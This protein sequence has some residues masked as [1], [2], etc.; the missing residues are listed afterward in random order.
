MGALVSTDLG[1]IQL[2]DPRSISIIK[3]EGGGLLSMSRKIRIGA[4][5]VTLAAVTTM[6][7]ATT[8]ASAFTIKAPFE[9]WKVTGSL[10][11]KKLNQTIVFPEGGTF[12]G[13]AVVEL[14]AVTGSVTGTT[15]IPTFETEVKILG[16]PAKV[17]VSFV[18]AGTVAG[19]IAANPTGCE[20]R[21][22]CVNLSVPTKENI[23]LN[24]LKIL[25]ITLPEKCE[26]SEPGLLALTDTLTLGELISVG[27]HFTGTTS[28]AS[29]KC[30]GPIGGL[31]GAVLTSLMSGPEN[32]Y[33]INIAP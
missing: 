22:A 3:D 32:P 8:S 21:A 12:N 28:I 18:Q 27:S 5:V 6:L 29:I 7:V 17:Q 30:A 9:N 14:P 19:S 15:T 20:G 24:N 4:L 25:G 16:F 33:A 31:E 23:V 26:T 2:F 1:S 13:E 10:T 11:V